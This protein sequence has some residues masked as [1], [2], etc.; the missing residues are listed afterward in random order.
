MTLGAS[1]RQWDSQTGVTAKVDD[2]LP[3]PNKDMVK[4]DI[5][6]IG[7]C[8]TD[9]HAFTGNQAFFTYPRILGHELAVTIA[10]IPEGVPNPRGVKV[11]DVCAVEPY[12]HCGSC[13]SCSL[14]KT[15]CCTQIKVLGV[16]VD[17]GMQPSMFLPL[18]K[19]HPCT[20]DKMPG[21]YP[22]VALVETLC[23]GAHAVS[24]AKENGPVT[25]EWCLIVGAGPVG[26]A[27]SQFVNAEGGKIIMMDINQDRLDFATSVLGIEHTVC[28]D[29]SK[30]TMEQIMA[31][32]GG[33][34]PTCVFEV[35][36]NIHSMKNTFNLVSHGGRLVFVGHTKEEV[37]YNNPQFHSHEMTV[38]GSRNA[39]ATD[40]E[41]TIELIESG[42]IDVKP[43]VTHT[44]QQS[45]FLDN[46]DAWR[47]PATGVIKAVVLRQ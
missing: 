6:A 43:W 29:K 14:G 15:N 40:F 17:G 44:C 34:P 25:D 20:L 30:D 35:T 7:V 11:G 3:C 18:A 16:H 24:R 1:N 47:D 22:T 41:K 27:T 21:G 39:R 23:I 5:N 46:F 19:C 9:Y 36:G 45:E 37:S 38:L 42:K 2:K 26:M 33:M 4:V 28:V 12:M 32:T 31:I 8:G 13:I 10:D